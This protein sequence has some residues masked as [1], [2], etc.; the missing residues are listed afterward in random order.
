MESKAHTDP[1]SELNNYKYATT[2]TAHMQWKPDIIKV[3]SLISHV[4]IPS[5][6][7]E[8]TLRISITFERESHSNI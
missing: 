2:Q 4:K 5:V 6:C 3:T 8:R 7:P 1:P